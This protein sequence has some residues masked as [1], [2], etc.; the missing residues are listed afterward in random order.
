MAD[1]VEVLWQGAVGGRFDP[2]SLVGHWTVREA[3][4][5]QLDV[6]ERWRLNG[7]AVAGWK[8]AATSRPGRLIRRRSIRVAAETL[9]VLAF[10]HSATS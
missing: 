2:S 7:D 8:V 5:I 4:Q 10:D 9:L 1:P 6:L 3:E